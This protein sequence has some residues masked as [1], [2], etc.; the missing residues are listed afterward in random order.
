MKDLSPP[1]PPPP[2]RKAGW[3]LPTF[4]NDVL[5]AFANSAQQDLLLYFTNQYR[6]YDRERSF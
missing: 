2:A 1:P 3:M 4:V 5:L 6:L